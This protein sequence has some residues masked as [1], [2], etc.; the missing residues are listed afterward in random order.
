MLLPASCK[1]QRDIEQQL[2]VIIEK[3]KMQHFCMFLQFYNVLTY[4]QLAG[5]YVDAWPF[6]PD[7][8]SVCEAMDEL[9]WQ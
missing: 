3:L 5:T 1:E 2:D 4:K 7:A 8:F 6:V 9:D